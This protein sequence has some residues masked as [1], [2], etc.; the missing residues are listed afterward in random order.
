MSLP[1]SRLS[2]FDMLVMAVLDQ[3][4]YKILMSAIYFS[5]MMEI[6]NDRMLAIQNVILVILSGILATLNARWVIW[7][8]IYV[9]LILNLQTLPFFHCK[10]FCKWKVTLHVHSHT[11]QDSSPSSNCILFHKLSMFNSL[12][13]TESISAA[14]QHDKH[15][16]HR[17]TCSRFRRDLWG[18]TI[19]KV[20]SFHTQQ[21]NHHVLSVFEFGWKGG[22]FLTVISI[23]TT[24]AI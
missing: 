13:Y 11:Y 22:V 2:C 18:H 8:D 6:Y 1:H 3:K 10:N 5:M 21:R 23:Q 15:E 14:Q 16:R 9:D 20:R 12:S 17:G 4:L 19:L 24:G 7:S